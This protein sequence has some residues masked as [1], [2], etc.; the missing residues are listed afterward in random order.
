MSSYPN[1]DRYGYQVQRE[2]GQ[3]CT[4]G[5]V[6][7]LAT[8]TKTQL[9]VVIKQFQFAQIGSNWAE[10]D[11]YQSEIQILQ[12][13]NHPHIPRYLDAFDMPSGFCLVQEYKN[14][15][16]LAQPRHFNPQEIKQI[17]VAVLAV[18]VYLQQQSPPII[19]RDIK[20]EN[21]LVDRSQ[22]FQV[23]LVDFG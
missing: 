21:I 4:G 23:Y 11:R 20:P 12:K 19:H 6:T 13:L 22:G 8:N 18:L 5:R 16:S 9:P 7:Y 2:L 14:A 10:Y 17:A 1:F 15:P 3:N